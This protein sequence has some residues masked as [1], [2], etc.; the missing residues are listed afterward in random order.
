MHLSPDTCWQ[1]M[2]SHD[3]RYDGMFFVGVMSTKIY[4][5][6]SCPARPLQRNVRFFADTHQARAAGLRACKRCHPDELSSEAMLVHAV[7]RYIDAHPSATQLTDISQ[8]TGYS[9]FHI[10]RQFKRIIGISPRQYATAV[11]HHRLDL[12]LLAG[13]TREHAHHM[14]G[15]NSLSSMY[16]AR[17]QRQ[18]A[19]PP[20][21]TLTYSTHD[22]SLGQLVLV[23]STVGI[24]FVGFSDTATGVRT[25]CNYYFPGV[26]WSQPTP[27]QSEQL[28]AIVAAIDHALP[29]PSDIALDI[30]M[31][32]FQ[33]RVWHA[34]R[35]I[36]RGT[37]R[38]YQEIATA[39]GQPS[40]ARAVAQACAHNPVAVI[41]PCHRVIHHDGTMAGYRWGSHRKQQ[42]LH[43]E[44]AQQQES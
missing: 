29:I 39:I 15:F 11:R 4:C 26:A 36:P 18:S 33:E 22:T 38:S 34:L 3:K 31:T 14:A 20:D 43:T 28:Y 6:P 27:Q 5:R 1:M 8:H 13:H 2:Q 40:A 7:C 23:Y 35:Q 10:S 19:Q 44:A 16:Y 41:I 25:F 30:R 17:Q 12:A 42:L 24:R 9:P 32:A 37:T 21:S